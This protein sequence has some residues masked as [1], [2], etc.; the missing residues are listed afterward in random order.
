MFIIIHIAIPLV[1]GLVVAN[2]VI[3]NAK[4]RKELKD[5]L[6]DIKTSIF[7]THPA[8][9][10]RIKHAIKLKQEGI[11]TLEIPSKALFHNLDK[12]SEQV[13]LNFYEA[14]IGEEELGQMTLISAEESTR[15]LEHL[16]SGIE[17]TEQLYGFVPPYDSP[18]MIKSSELKSYFNETEMIQELKRIR[19]KIEHAFADVRKKSDEFDILDDEMKWLEFLGEIIKA[20]VLFD[21]WDYYD[22]SSTQQEINADHSKLG[23]KAEKLLG[24]LNKQRD[25]CKRRIIIS[26]SLLAQKP[27]LCKEYNALNNIQA[28]IIAMDALSKVHFEVMGLAKE[29]RVM[30]E[31]LN[32]LDDEPGVIA[33]FQDRKDKISK[34]IKRLHTKLSEFNY[35]FE[36]PKGEINIGE[37]IANDLAEKETIYDLYY[38]SGAIFNKMRALYFRCLGKLVSYSEKVEISLGFGELPE[39]KDDENKES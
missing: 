30:S 32:R 6:E 29:L 38:S 13:S 9:S 5:S 27:E 23:K 33:V 21:F 1:I 35:P 28:L 2:R 24:P 16:V 15:D 4:Q 18:V 14:V 22:R 7:D 31:V 20:G 17:K 11:F 26:L 12:I 3:I 39:V 37:Y 10:K 19:V 36:H 25:L 8:P 34:R